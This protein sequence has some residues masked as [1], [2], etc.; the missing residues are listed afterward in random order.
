MARVSVITALLLMLLLLPGCSY[1]R[2]GKQHHLVL[3][4]GVVTVDTNSPATIVVKSTTVGL[5][6]SLF[7][8]GRCVVGFSDT[9][10]IMAATN[11]NV[12]IEIK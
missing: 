9:T 5:G 4:F 7:P 11:Q 6:A 3:G 12:V 2:G 8:V 1:Y 10:A